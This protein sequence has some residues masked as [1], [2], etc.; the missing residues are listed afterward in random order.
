M[1]PGEVPSQSIPGTGLFIEP[2]LKKGLLNK[3]EGMEE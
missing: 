1:K 3:H 2:G